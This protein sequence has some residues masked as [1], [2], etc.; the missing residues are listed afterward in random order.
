[1]LLNI[2]E[3][4]VEERKKKKITQ[5][6]L[7]DFIG[8][9][10]ASVSKWENSQSYPDIS[11]LPLLAAYFDLS[12]DE[13]VSYQS[14]LSTKEIQNIYRSLQVSLQ[15]SSED[16]WQSIQSLL[17]RYY[18]CHPFILQIGVFLINHADSLS[19]ANDQ[20]EMKHYIS[21]AKELFERVI[22]HGNDSKMMDHA[23]KM[24]AYCSL[25]L[26]ESE[27]VIAILGEQ[28]SALLPPEILI[29]GA[30]QQK[31]DIES[32]ISV[33]QSGIFQYVV[34]LSSS[35]TNYLQLIIHQPT[36]FEETV[37]RGL[38]FGRIFCLEKL[39]PINWLNF[40]TS[41]AVG[42]AVMKKE[43]RLFEILDIFAESLQ[44]TEFPVKLHG[45][46][47]FDRVE[48]WIEKLDLGNQAPR[49]ANLI[50]QDFTELVLEHPALKPYQQEKQ[51]QQILRKMTNK[52]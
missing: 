11:L 6:E 40:L 19:G 51:M 8:V 37:A 39:H 7:A 42:F 1:M 22:H 10:K 29:A 41:A 43:E 31:G 3:V 47:Y 46:D 9:T 2:G 4:L 14:Q 34:V 15:K 23:L 17:K 18:S 28:T 52:E 30:Y 49:E 36:L 12:I 20:E 38:S 26:G 24:A 13:L 35:L 32:A 16:T 33:S 45:D 44:K 25:L 27:E 21:K 50:K 5:Q 48:D